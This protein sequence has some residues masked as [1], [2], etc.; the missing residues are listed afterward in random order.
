MEKNNITTVQIL[1][2][3]YNL[4]KSLKFF[5]YFAMQENCTPEQEKEA[6]E[7]ENGLDKIIT[8]IAFDLSQK[9]RDNLYDDDTSTSI[10]KSAN[11]LKNKI[12]SSTALNQNNET[13]IVLRDLTNIA[14]SYRTDFGIHAIESLQPDALMKIKEYSLVLISEKFS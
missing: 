12:I 14:N 1:D 6:K 9:V 2:I 13:T 11:E 7:I 5:S 3:I 8:A 4:E 10:E